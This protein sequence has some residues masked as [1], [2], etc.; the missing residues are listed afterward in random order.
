MGGETCR[1][2]DEPLE[3][4]PPLPCLKFL[5]GSLCE[6]RSSYGGASICLSKTHLTLFYSSGKNIGST[7][8]SRCIPLNERSHR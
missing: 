4:C 1:R 7:C 5:A 2:G 8:L 3:P 6:P